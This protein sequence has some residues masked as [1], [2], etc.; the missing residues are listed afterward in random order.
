[1]FVFICD[2]GIFGRWDGLSDGVDLILFYIDE[3]DLDFIL[4]GGDYVYVNWDFWFVDI[5]F[6]ID[7]F[8]Y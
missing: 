4:V 7:V 1:M 6:V 5:L 8:F 2:I 3:Y